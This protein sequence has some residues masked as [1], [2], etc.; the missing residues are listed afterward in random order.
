MFNF[1]FVNPK[2]LFTTIVDLILLYTI[3]IIAILSTNSARHYTT[4]KIVTFFTH[5]EDI[6]SSDGNFEEAK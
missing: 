6:P 5:S 1:N 3:V 2:N 4:H